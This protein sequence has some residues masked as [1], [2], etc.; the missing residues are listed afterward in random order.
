MMYIQT[1][2]DVQWERNVYDVF[3]SFRGIDTGKNFTDYLYTS[4][5]DAGIHTFKYDNELHVGEKIGSNLLH[6]ITQSKISIPIISENYAFSKWCL[7]EL[8]HMLKCRRKASQIVLPIFYKVEPSQLRYPTGKLRDAISAHEKNM[9]EMVVKEWK[10]VLKEVSLLKGWESEKIANGYEGSLVQIVVRNVTRE[11]KGLYQLDVPKHLVGIDDHVEEIMS[12]IDAKPNDTRIIGIYGM[13]G[14]GK[15]TLAKVLYNKLSSRYHFRSFVANIRVESQHTGIKELQ[16]QLIYDIVG[17]A[18]DIHNVDDGIC[19][20]KSRFITREVL[21]LL[22]DMDDY[23]HF[24][25]LIREKDW[26]Q[27]RSIVLITTTN[28]RILDRV[29]ADY[30]YQLP[31]LKLDQAL[32]LFSKHA[33]G[34]DFPLS[35]YEVISRE[36]VLSIGGLPLALEVKGSFLRGKS[37][38]V[39]KQELRKLNKVPKTVEMSYEALDDNEQQI[40][41]DIACFFIGS[42]KQSPT[43]MWAACGFFPRKGIEVLSLKSLVNIDKDG[44]LMMDDQLRD[45]GRKIALE[46]QEEP[47]QRS[48]IWIYKEAVDVLDSNKGNSK[49]EALCLDECDY[50]RT[51]T[52]EQFEGLTNL[53]FLKVCGAN[54][55]GD[56]HNLLPHLKWLQWEHCPTNFRA[57]NFHPRELVVLNLSWSKISEDW[58][59]WGPLKMAIK[60]KVLNLTGC[61]S[62]RRTPDLSAYKSLEILILEECENMEEID[63]SIE[64]I[65]T[66]VSLNVSSC[67]RLEEL[68]KGVGRMEELRELFIN[69]TS[70]QEI[71][72]SGDG[73]MKLETLRAS[74]CNRLEELPV[75]VGRM[76]KLRELLIDNTSVQEIPIS[77]DGLM[78]LETLSA[79]GCRRLKELPTEVGRMEELRELILDHTNIQEIPISGSGLMK[80][81]ILNV[82]SCRRIEELPAQVGHMKELRELLIN[83]TAIREIPISSGGLMK[84]KTLRA[85]YCEEL[86]QLPNSMGSLTLL[87]QL[88][89]SHSGIEKLPEF[90]S[91]FNLLTQLNL[92]YLGIKE[93]PESVGSLKWLT[94]LDLSHSEIEEL[95]KSI[96]SL[97]SLTQLHISHSWIEELPKAMSSLESLTLLDLSHSGIGEFPKFMSSLVSLAQLDLSHT[98]IEELPESIGCLK[99]LQILNVSCCGLA[100]IPHSIGDLAYLSLLDLRQC[101]KLTQLPNSIGFAMSLQHLLLQG[102]HL[103][104]EIPNSIKKLTSL[105]ELDL[106]ST[107]IVELPYGIVNLQNLTNLDIRGTYITR[108]PVDF[109]T[110]TIFKQ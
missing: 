46:N 86:A 34:R 90:M 89:L 66:L 31:K 36:V 28:K 45:F 79:S 50:R 24:D 40:F 39:W 15:T 105:I 43:Y 51:Y 1:R 78:K 9:D 102:C 61:R 97:V 25:V 110:P 87:H 14:I 77:G 26:L 91:S 93:L 27:A 92:S 20:I 65:K 70:I 107:A 83:D 75:G 30:T 84:L 69:D 13:A 32:I 80:L 44:K 71:P 18:H 96:S 41:L 4:L 57:A 63:S 6:A 106:N 11:L 76:E 29:R 74:C 5:V 47:E 19:I 42:S 2:G 95:P 17:R 8:A 60:L 52:S 53:R 81:Q 99:K 64:D 68:P 37:E 7:C 49:I 54:F 21:I 67:T 94:Q 12:E 10:E 48:R 23:K 72:L 3:L 88:D 35:N 108:L 22:D 73:L 104:R 62:L 58:G 98:G 55:T 56:F 85:S 16:K 33:F 100:S 109:K 59:G 82:S 101:N 38:T 103:L